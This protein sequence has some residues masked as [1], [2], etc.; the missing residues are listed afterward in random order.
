MP[1]SP[2]YRHLRAL[3][4]HNGIFEH[5]LFDVPRRDHGYCVDDVARALIVVTREPQQTASLRKLSAVY[6]R[7]LEAAIS[8]DGLAHNRMDAEGEWSDTPTMGDWWGRL[9]WAL[10][11]VVAQSEDPWTRARALRA[12]R[13]AARERCVS[14]RTR[15]FAAL[16]AAEI[17]RVRPDDP[18]ARTLLREF[19][20][21][22]PTLT[23]PAWLWPEHRL[24]YAN[25]SIA[26]AL[27][28][29][30]HALGYP[31]VREQGLR[32]LD[33][34]LSVEMSQGRFS[35]TGAG[36]RGP[37]ETG[38]SF[39]QQPIELAALA[40]ACASAY[41][42]TSD[43]AWLRPIAPAWGWFTG[44]NDGATVM[45]D[46]ATGAGFDGLERSGRN[47]NRGA[48]STLAALST[49]QQASRHRQ[50]NAG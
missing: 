20:A 7:F 42:A 4:D 25:A 44:L 6:L 39:D 12:F 32:M 3:T 9:L 24:A 11:T 27:I 19:V 17:A 31:D 47:E 1:A 29:A 5:A 37:G 15:A 43:A 10:G 23:D 49:Y 36:G 14:L 38:P 18:I 2:S 34:L 22:V 30:G 26:D 50:M 48:E 41:A 35:V 45:F 28:A 8:S 16:G 21:E 33:F 13:R 46:E 40:D